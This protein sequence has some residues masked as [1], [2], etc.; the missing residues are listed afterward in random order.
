MKEEKSLKKETQANDCHSILSTK[1][2]NDVD[3]YNNTCYTFPKRENYVTLERSKSLKAQYSIS[4]YATLSR[5]RLRKS[6]PVDQPNELPTRCQNDNGT[7]NM[8]EKALDNG[9]I[10]RF[11]IVKSDASKRRKSGNCYSKKC[12][13]KIFSKNEKVKIKLKI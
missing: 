8:V 4:K 1:S 5:V 6:I 13:S 12:G 2:A 9:S 10:L 11:E 3:S 7:K